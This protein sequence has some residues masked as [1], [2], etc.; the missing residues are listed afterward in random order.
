LPGRVVGRL[1]S[2][3]ALPSI[4]RCRLALTRAGREDS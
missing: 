2:P 3:V 1:G 4:S